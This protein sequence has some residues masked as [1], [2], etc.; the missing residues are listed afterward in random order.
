MEGGEQSEQDK[1][2]VEKLSKLGLSQDV[3][4]KI[5]RTSKELG[6]PTF[7]IGIPGDTCDITYGDDTTLR[8]S[9]AKEP[10]G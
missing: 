5:L 2:L 9:I 10:G 3:E 7:M 8:Y 4:A 1:E 6:T